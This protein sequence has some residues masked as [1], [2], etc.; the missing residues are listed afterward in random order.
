[1]KLPD[2]CNQ[3]LSKCIDNDAQ[4][5]KLMDKYKEVLKKNKIKECLYKYCPNNN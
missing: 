2:S 5:S 3:T 4:L 1:M